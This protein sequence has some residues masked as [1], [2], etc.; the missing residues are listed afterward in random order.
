MAKCYTHRNIN[1]LV[2]CECTGE[3]CFGQQVLDGGRSCCPGILDQYH[4]A[5]WVPSKLSNDLTTAPAWAWKLILKFTN[6]EKKRKKKLKTSLVPSTYVATAMDT[7]FLSS[8]VSELLTH[9]V[10]A[11]LSAQVLRGY[12]AFSMLQPAGGKRDL[13]CQWH[14]LAQ[15]AQRKLC[16]V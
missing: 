16:C 9:F 10:I 1:I 7:I 15:Q 2:L 12:A 4:L 3:E 13:L 8:S 5:V 6:I 14:L 11:T